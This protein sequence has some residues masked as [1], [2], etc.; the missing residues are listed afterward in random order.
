MSLMAQNVQCQQHLSAL[1]EFFRP[2]LNI[3]LALSTIRSTAA[4]NFPSPTNS[5]SPPPGYRNWTHEGCS[6]VHSVN[7]TSTASI[8]KYYNQWIKNQLV[9]DDERLQFYINLIFQYCQHCGHAVASWLRHYAANRKVA[10]S[11]PDDVIRFFNWP[12]PS[13]RTMVLLSTQPL[14]KMITRN[15]PGDKKRPARKTNNLTAICE[16]NV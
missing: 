3:P 11:I 9:T 16:L 10:G 7:E 13:N 6:L 2:F 8:A 1:F 5:G 14:T 15:L 12:I 4:L